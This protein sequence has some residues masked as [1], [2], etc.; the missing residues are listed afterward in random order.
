MFTKEPVPKEQKE[1]KLKKIL[2]IGAGASGLISAIYAKKAGNEVTLIEKNEICGK[3]IL[4]TG[5][6]RCNFWNEDQNLN[7][8]RSS[9]YEKLEEVLNEK[10]QKETL[11]FFNKIGIE[12]KI[13][14]GY[15]YPYSNQAISIQKA[16]ILEAKKQGVNIKTN[17]E[18]TNIIKK[19]EKFE[20]II[21]EQN[22][23]VSDIVILSVGSKAAPKT[24]SDGFGYKICKQF[25]HTINK[26]LPAL[27]QLK[28]EENFLKDWEGIRADVSVKLYENGKEIAEE[29][30]EIQLTNYGISGIC[31]FNLSGRVAKG[32]EANKK[33]CVR[34]NFLDG[35]KIRNEN[36][37]IN[38]MNSRNRILEDRNMTEALEGIL[39]F[40]LV[41]VLLKLSNIN[42]F[43]KWD[44]LT[45][46]QK[47]KLAQNIIKFRLNITGTNSFDKAQVCTGG[48]PI[49]EIDLKTMQ[50]RKEHGLFITGET[51]DVDGDC[52][53][54]NL[55]W[56]WI[57]GMIAGSNVK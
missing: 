52:G 16:L 33:E 36:Q 5:N 18:V 26:P 48:V 46:K 1:K 4:A 54:Y 32:L 49:E 27:V 56:A 12:P 29:I 51:L 45:E 55:E 7:H 53:G 22:K 57:T 37:F 9:N 31:V 34:I 30:G 17:S 39:N 38:W 13:K 47:N 2:I 28:A 19:N 14:N 6:G 8:Y 24:G 23:I 40:K 44:N 35:L 20:T 43:E 11:N 21:K 10:N 3:K 41:K 15:Y 50:S 42:L 25:G